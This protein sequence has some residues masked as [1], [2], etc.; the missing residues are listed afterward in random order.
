MPNGQPAAMSVDMTPALRHGNNQIDIR[1]TDNGTYHWVFFDSYNI[2]ASPQQ[3]LVPRAAAQ[4]SLIGDKDDFHPG[5]L[6]DTAP[7]DLEQPALNQSVGLTHDVTIA[8]GATMIEYKELSI[9]CTGV[10]AA[11]GDL[12]N[13]GAVNRDDLN[14]L[15]PCL[16]TLASGPNDPR[17]LDHDGRITALGALFPS[18]F[19]HSRPALI[20]IFCTVSA[21]RSNVRQ[22]ESRTP[23]AEA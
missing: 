15:L 4:I 12:S 5:D 20:A 13:G 19:S 11:P 1:A 18:P 21:V 17:G 8:E 14:L 22:R 2:N 10:S 3:V 6:A 16:N 9:T 7:I 23:A